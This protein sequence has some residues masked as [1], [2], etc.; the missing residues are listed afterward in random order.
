MARLIEILEEPKSR[1]M[2]NEAI[3]YAVGIVLNSLFHLFIAHPYMM[4]MLHQGMKIRVA[5]CS[6]IYRKVCHRYDLN[7]NF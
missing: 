2:K 5:T 3:F 6:L 4:A 1:I 7:I